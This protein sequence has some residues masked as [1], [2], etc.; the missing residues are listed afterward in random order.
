MSQLYYIN[1]RIV[2]RKNQPNQHECKCEL[3]QFLKKI[4]N[5]PSLT[6]YLEAELFLTPCRS[7]TTEI[8]W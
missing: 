3:S 2:N 7:Q 6:K 5:F 1:I 8:G 4:N